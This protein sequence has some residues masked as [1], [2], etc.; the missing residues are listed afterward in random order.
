MSVAYTLLLHCLAATPLLQ[1]KDTTIQ[2][3]GIPCLHWTGYL[4]MLTGMSLWCSV[5]FF[6]WLGPTVP[7]DEYIT[8]NRQGLPTLWPHPPGRLT[9]LL[10]SMSHISLA[11]NLMLT[12]PCSPVLMCLSIASRCTHHPQPTSTYQNHNSSKPCTC[13]CMAHM[14]PV[15]VGCF[16]GLQ[17]DKSTFFFFFFFQ[18]CAFVYLNTYPLATLICPHLHLARSWSSCA[19]ARHWQQP[20]LHLHC[21]HHPPMSPHSFC[22]CP[23]VGMWPTTLFAP[24]IDCCHWTASPCMSSLGMYSSPLFFFCFFVGFLCVFYVTL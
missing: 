19:V 7:W 5:F 6:G 22:A 4:F 10:N 15:E 3:D 21:I 11:H 9:S 17:I 8:L 12:H 18:S 20:C 1:H 13:A 16:V 23:V 14:V 2:T 24:Q